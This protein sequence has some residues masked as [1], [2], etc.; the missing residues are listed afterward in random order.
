[1]HPIS[2]PDAMTTMTEQPLLPSE[3]LEHLLRAHEKN[4]PDSPLT[5]EAIIL[6][7]EERVWGGLFFLFGL[8]NFL[9]PPGTTVVTSTPM[10]IVAA[11]ATWG[12]HAPWLPR[13][14][15]NIPIAP[16]SI[17][18]MAHKIRPWEKRL[19]PIIRPRWMNMTNAFGVRVTATIILL[20]SG[21]IWLPIPFGNHA[22]SLAVTIMAAGLLTRNGLILCLGYATTLASLTLLALVAG[23]I[24]K[25]AMMVYGLIPAFLQTIP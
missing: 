17:Q 22:P 10:I 8:I 12:R 14:I 6:Y 20:L 25:L 18:S 11:Q 24:T 19:A 3:L 13:K 4:A 9:A 5:L 2:G 15:L 21:I 16:K 23:T 1:M 7:L